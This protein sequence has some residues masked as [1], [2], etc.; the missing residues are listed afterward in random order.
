MKPHGIPEAPAELISLLGGGFF[1]VSTPVDTHCACTFSG[2]LEISNGGTMSVSVA[3]VEEAT[4]LT[5]KI[6]KS[7]EEFAKLLHEAWKVKV[8]VA[9]DYSGF[10]EWLAEEIGISRSRG[11]QLIA[12]AQLEELVRDTIKPLPETFILSDSMTRAV[13]AHGVEAVMELLEAEATDDAGENL[14]AIHRIVKDLQTVTPTA[15]SSGDGSAADTSNVTEILTRQVGD[16][17]R[18]QHTIRLQVRSFMNMADTIPHPSSIEDPTILREVTA[19]L[20]DTTKHL[21]DRLAEYETVVGQLPDEEIHLDE[22][23]AE[24]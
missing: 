5:K 9:L 19:T 23:A 14:K 10:R 13:T 1:Y 3:T 11:Y 20:R 24:A 18:D 21:N 22:V 6:K 8:W 7:T 12:I 2:E 15:A 16:G 4:A 17:V